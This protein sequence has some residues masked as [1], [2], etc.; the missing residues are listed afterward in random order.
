MSAASTA[1]QQR[2]A[3]LEQTITRS[4]AAADDIE[5]GQIDMVQEHMRDIKDA[6]Q[7]VG[8]APLRNKLGTISERSCRMCTPST[9]HWKKKIQVKMS[10][11]TPKLKLLTK[12]NL[13]PVLN[14]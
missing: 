4:E 10:V 9:Q 8:V 6:Y 1:C 12:Q 7:K 2:Q 3:S 5:A 11:N 13:F 14:E